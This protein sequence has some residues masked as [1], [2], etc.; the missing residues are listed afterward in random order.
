MC[1]GI[2]RFDGECLAVML[3]R[4]VQFA[5]RLER[6]PHIVVRFGII[7]LDGN[8]FVLVFDRFV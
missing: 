3:D 7:R 8:R 4:F 5:L 6:K 2:I 1:L